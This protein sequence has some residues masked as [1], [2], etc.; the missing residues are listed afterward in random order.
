MNET[1]EVKRLNCMFLFITNAE[2]IVSHCIMEK[3]FEVYVAEI[4]TRK[5]EGKER[6]HNEKRFKLN[7]RQL[8]ETKV[9]RK[10]KVGG[11]KT[12]IHFLDPLICFVLLSYSLFCFFPLHLLPSSGSL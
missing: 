2:Q 5:E 1:S 8:E 12:D 6:V 4:E 7:G 11:K 3:R 9:Q 10:M